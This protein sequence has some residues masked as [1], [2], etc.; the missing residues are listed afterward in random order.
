MS[1]CHPPPL[2]PFGNAAPNPRFIRSMRGGCVYCWHLSPVTQPRRLC[3]GNNCCVN[4]MPFCD[5]PPMTG[6]SRRSS[7]ASGTSFHVLPKHAAPGAWPG[8][9]AS[10]WSQQADG[11]MKSAVHG[12]CL[13]VPSPPCPS[14]RPYHKSPAVD[15]DASCTPSLSHVFPFGRLSLVTT[16]CCGTYQQVVTVRRRDTE[17]PVGLPSA[18]LRA[19]H[20]APVL[21][22]LFLSPPRS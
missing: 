1:R 6:R 5:P 15:E 12:E 14:M 7:G 13:S 16:S 17:G 20:M 8:T 10:Y 18:S 3:Y 11:S 22:P 21:L 19:L 9:R 2:W 4:I